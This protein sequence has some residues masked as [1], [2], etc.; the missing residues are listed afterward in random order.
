MVRHLHDIW[1][2]PKEVADKYPEYYLN[3]DLAAMQQ[4][5]PEGE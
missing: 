5:F 2:V 4:V 1:D 3:E